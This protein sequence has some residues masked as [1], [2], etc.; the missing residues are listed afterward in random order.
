MRKLGGSGARVGPLLHEQVT[1]SAATRADV[2]RAKLNSVS[3]EEKPGHVPAHVYVVRRVV[4]TRDA[5][6]VNS[7]SAK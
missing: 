1:I 3:T 6:A 2:E 7:G 5:A 4:A